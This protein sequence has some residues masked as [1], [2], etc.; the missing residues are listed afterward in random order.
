MGRK[1]VVKPSPSVEA[2]ASNH[3]GAKTTMEMAYPVALAVQLRNILV[4]E[5]SARR[6]SQGFTDFE[7][8]RIETRI[9]EAGIGLPEGEKMFN[10]FLRFSLKVYATDNGQK[11]EEP[12]V[13]IECRFVI[14]YFLPS[15]EG[16]LIENLKAFG[17]TSGVFSAWPYWREFVHSTSLRLSVPPIILPTYRIAGAN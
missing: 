6:T 8:T 9:N 1:K 2:A 5:C 13:E 14:E 17:G 12:A 10:V 3:R 4:D 7:R 16:L 11:A 15:M